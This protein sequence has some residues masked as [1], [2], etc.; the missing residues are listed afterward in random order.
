MFECDLHTATHGFMIV[1][2]RYDH[3]RTR[4]RL[5]E[6]HPPH[7]RSKTKK[8][9]TVSKF[10]PVTI[11]HVERGPASWDLSKPGVATARKR[12]RQLWWFPAY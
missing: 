8:I 3:D 5:Q 7:L 1:H 10:C 4:A 11:I 2:D 12:D 9:D 6:D